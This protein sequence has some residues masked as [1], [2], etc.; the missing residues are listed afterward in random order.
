[1]THAH[2]AVAAQMQPDQRGVVGLRLRKQ[3]SVG[4]QSSSQ[5]RGR[6]SPFSSAHSP[7]NG[8]CG[9][10]ARSSLEVPIQQLF[11]HFVNADAVKWLERLKD[12]FPTSFKRLRGK[13]NPTNNNCTAEDVFQALAYRIKIKVHGDQKHSSESNLDR[14]FLYHH[15][16]ELERWFRG[17]LPDCRMI[18]PDR[19]RC[20][21]G[22][23]VFDIEGEDA[24]WINS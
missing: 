9:L 19:A 16:E 21:L 13:R 20:M 11:E 1:M 7:F 4:P 24:D 5:Q 22:L 8:S 2:A 3:I 23:L 17:R 12:K 14:D 10:R 6:S 15:C 18:K